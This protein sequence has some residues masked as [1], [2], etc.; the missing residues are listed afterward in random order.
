MDIRF[1]SGLIK[2]T[3]ENNEPFPGKSIRM[4]GEALTNGFDAS[5][6]T[7]EWMKDHVG[8]PVNKDDLLKIR[9]AI[10]DNNAKKSF[11]VLFMGE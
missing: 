3:F 8:Y 1:S 4:K 9:K 10:D 6:E 11:Q 2:I 7:C 5:L